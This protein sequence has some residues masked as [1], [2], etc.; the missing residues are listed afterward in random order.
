MSALNEI[1]NSLSISPSTNHFMHPRE[2]TQTARCLETV[3]YIKP[4]LGWTGF[5]SDIHCC[6]TEWE[7]FYWH[8]P[9]SCHALCEPQLMYVDEV[10]SRAVPRREETPSRTPQLQWLCW[11]P[12][13]E[14]D[15]LTFPS[16]LM[17]EKHN[18]CSSP[19]HPAVILGAYEIKLTS[20]KDADQSSNGVFCS[21]NV[22]YF[23]LGSF[24]AQEWCSISFST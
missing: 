8:P 5:P 1:N 18:S 7:V 6:T 16:S 14:P 17:D 12:P 10:T 3:K 13:P 4:G 21:S 22:L 24:T 23:L 15:S 20:S 2:D 9:F 19:C 11:L